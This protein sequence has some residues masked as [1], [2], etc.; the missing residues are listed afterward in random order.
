MGQQAYQKL[1]GLAQK[2]AQS[3]P[4]PVFYEQFKD[5]ILRAV[6]ALSTS[7]LIKKCRSYLDESQLECAHGV[8]HCE[9]VAQD[10]G[11]LILIEAR[12]VGIPADEV[13][14]LLV[15]TEIAGLLHDIKR[16]EKDHA[17]LG[18]IEAGRILTA[19]GLE[20]AER[21]YITNA[22]KNHEAFREVQGSN[23]TAGQLV[24][25]ALYDADKF[26]WGPDNFTTTLW[27]MV[28]S[29]NTP[30]Q[31]LHGVFKEKMEGIEK[32]KRTFRTTTGKKYGPEF[33]DQGLQIG[34]RIY[35]ELSAMLRQNDAP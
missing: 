15:A 28:E 34:D 19:I 4:L 13:D 6:E 25:D 33:I 30:P 10:A 14:R 27:L 18:S 22:I 5:E 9:T 35:E 7:S 31:A 17:V 20:G 12:G 24:S 16:K 2:T 1:Q 21:E 29:N 32:I 8:C 3:L 23:S 11:T 26:R